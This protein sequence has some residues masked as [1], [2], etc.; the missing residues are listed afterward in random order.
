MA[1]DNQQLGPHH[2]AARLFNAEVNL[3]FDGVVEHKPQSVKRTQY[4]HH[5]RHI[6]LFLYQED[7]NFDLGGDI[8][9][10]WYDVSPSNNF[11]LDSLDGARLF[12]LSYYMFVDLINPKLSSVIM[13]LSKEKNVAILFSKVRKIILHQI[14]R[15]GW[16][17]ARETLALAHSVAYTNVRGKT[18]NGIHSTYACYRHRKDPRRMTLDHFSLLSNTA[19]DIKKQV[20]KEI[21]NIVV[22]LEDDSRSV[23]HAMKSASTFLDVKDKQQ[24]PEVFHQ[25]HLDEGTARKALLLNFVSV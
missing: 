1:K 12:S 6:L 20:R 2:F 23:L 8:V 18:C 22:A 13:G 25:T 24:N 4:T 11:H 21:G 17:K 19:D 15:N 5:C 16:D 7:Y 3:I 9:Q 10:V 14:N